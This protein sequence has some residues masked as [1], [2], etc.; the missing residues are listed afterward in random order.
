MALVSTSTLDVAADTVTDELKGAG[1]GWIQ[2]DGGWALAALAEPGT[3]AASAAADVEEFRLHAEII[4]RATKHERAR[5]RMGLSA[6]RDRT[7]GSF[8]IRITSATKRSCS[9]RLRF[10]G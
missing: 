10:V 9:P 8:I 2:A 4:T 6:E 7:L 5:A 1:V 3:S